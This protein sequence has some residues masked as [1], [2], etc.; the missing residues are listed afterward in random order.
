MY[1][2]MVTFYSVILL[3][4][5]LVLLNKKKQIRFTNQFIF[6]F[7]A[8]MTWCSSYGPNKNK[9]E[10]RGCCQKLNVLTVIGALLFLLGSFQVV[11]GVYFM[12]TLPVFQIGSNIWTGAWVT[13]SIYSY[14]FH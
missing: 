6:S 10:R 3:D 12:I 2:C 7:F 4:C 5:L 8:V 13:I 14:N 11:A 1:F 9:F